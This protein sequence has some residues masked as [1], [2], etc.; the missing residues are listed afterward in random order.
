MFSL[1]AEI[2]PLAM[3]ALNAVANG[4]QA[5]FLVNLWQWKADRQ[6]NADEGRIHDGPDAGRTLPDLYPYKTGDLSKGPLTEHDPAFISAWQAGNPKSDPAM[7]VHPVLEANAQGIGTLT[8]QELRL[9]SHVEL[10]A[11]THLLVRLTN[12]GASHGGASPW[13][14]E[15]PEVANEAV[16]TRLDLRDGQTGVYSATYFRHRLQQEVARAHRYQRPLTLL[17]LRCAGAT[18]DEVAAK[19]A[20][21]LEGACRNVDLV[22]RIERDLFAVLL[23]ETEVSRCEPVVA[24]LE[25]ECR[26][27]MLGCRIGRAGLGANGDDGA[28][29][30]GSLLRLACART[31]G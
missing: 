23:P 7:L 14:R 2:P 4:D 20:T 11:R 31:D 3:G 16:G 15:D 17:A 6:I 5:A 18:R 30:A 29:S 13:R 10:L 8:W 19:L 21:I 28:Y 25:D 26:T 22:A 27:A 1:T 9:G 24:R 12:G